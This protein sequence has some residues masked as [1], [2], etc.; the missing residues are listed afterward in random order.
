MLLGN[1]LL[2]DGS[3][4]VTGIGEEPSLNWFDDLNGENIG[5]WIYD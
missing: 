2:R 1:L 3:L 5:E 4:I